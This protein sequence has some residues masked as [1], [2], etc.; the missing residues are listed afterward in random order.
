MFRGEIEPSRNPLPMP[1]TRSG[2]T[3]AS[4]VHASTEIDIPPPKPGPAN[5]QTEVKHS[6]Q[7]KKNRKKSRKSKPKSDVFE[8]KMSEITI[9]NSDPPLEKDIQEECKETKEQDETPALLPCRSKQQPSQSKKYKS[10]PSSR[11]A[12]VSN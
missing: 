10:T 8:Y 5:E 6:K 4:H 2:I 1:P 12:I 3:L 9:T 7:K 11:P